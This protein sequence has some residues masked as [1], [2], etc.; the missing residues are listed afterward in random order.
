MKRKKNSNSNNLI[1]FFA[2]LNIFLGFGILIL[3][4]LFF[5]TASIILV[6]QENKIINYVE[7]E[8]EILK[9]SLFENPSNTQ[10]DNNSNLALNLFEI[11]IPQNTAETMGFKIIIPKIGVDTY[12]YESMNGDIGLDKGVWRDP[13]RG[14]PDVDG[15]PT[16]LFAHRWGLDTFSNE[17]RSKN[18][19]LNIPS[20][21]K[22]DVIKLFWGDNIYEYYV[23][24]VEVRQFA[25]KESD[26]ILVTCRDYDSPLRYIVHANKINANSIN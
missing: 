14:R 21:N 7:R 4:S 6:N 13:L 1:K 18:L 19:F 8:N 20:L 12:I 11:K 5:I 9:V 10:I 15:L 17:Y 3:G 16:V 25:S 2:D 22:G 24:F 26:L 23:E